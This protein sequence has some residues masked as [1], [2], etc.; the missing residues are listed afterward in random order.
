MMTLC[1]VS[2]INTNVLTIVRQ[3]PMIFQRLANYSTSTDSHK[4]SHRLVDDQADRAR[5]FEAQYF[6]KKDTELLKEIAQKTAERQERQGDMLAALV[7][8]Y[9]I[10]PEDAEVIKTLHISKGS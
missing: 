10:T 2:P 8:K 5:A 3:S 4:S 9:N 7:K 1:K 6:R